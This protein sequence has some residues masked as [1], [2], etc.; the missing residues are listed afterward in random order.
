MTRDKL[1]QTVDALTK[2]AS[3]NSELEKGAFGGNDITANPIP[4]TDASQPPITWRGQPKNNYSNGRFINGGSISIFNATDESVIVRFAQTGVDFLTNLSPITV[5]PNGFGTKRLDVN[6]NKVDN[7]KRF[8]DSADGG[9]LVISTETRT[10]TI[11]ME[12]QIQRGGTYRRPG[13]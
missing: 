5:P 8:R 13:S 2:E 11:P 4:I 7:F 9:E 1:D 10:V 12:L 6:L 3:I